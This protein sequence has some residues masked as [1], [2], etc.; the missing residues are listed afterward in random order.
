MQAAP[1]PMHTMPL[2]VSRH[3]I[4]ATVWVLANFLS[5]LHKVPQ[6]KDDQP[7]ESFF[8]NTHMQN[9]VHRMCARFHII[10]RT[11]HGM[12]LTDWMCQEL[13]RVY[14]ALCNKEPTMRASLRAHEYLIV[15]MLMAHVLE[16]ILRVELD[17]YCEYLD[18]HA[19]GDDVSREFMDE[20]R[21]KIFSDPVPAMVKTWHMYMEFFC[22]LRQTRMSESQLVQLE[23]QCKQLQHQIW[24]AYPC[25]AG[26]QHR[27]NFIKFHH[28]HTFA[29]TFRLF[30][31]LEGMSTQ[32]TEHTHTFYSGKLITLTNGKGNVG[33]QIMTRLA[34]MQTIRDLATV[35]TGHHGLTL[36]KNFRK[37]TPSKSQIYCFPVQRLLQEHL[38]VTRKLKSPLT[39]KVSRTRVPYTSLGTWAAIRQS[40][41]TG[42]T[43]GPVFQAWPKAFAYLPYLLGQY[44]WKYWRHKL[45]IPEWD[46]VSIITCDKCRLFYV[47]ETYCFTWSCRLG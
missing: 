8:D 35:Y 14:E 10:M 15:S 33:A 40:S 23:D 12:D 38:Q 37:Y 30:G 32:A 2:G 20:A 21:T 4:Q 1:D 46:N 36:E 18:Q 11:C 45:D 39:I 43:A 31:S 7:T 27:W 24:I 28:M 25:K 5:S 47:H 41:S 44:L 19:E 17:L 42:T 6:H 22:A 34:V 29:C 9:V 13:Q 16:D 3:L 26:S